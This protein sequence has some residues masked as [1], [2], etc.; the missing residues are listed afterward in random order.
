MKKRINTKILELPDLQTLII[1]I[2]NRLN[3]AIRKTQLINMV[4]ELFECNSKSQVDFAILG[5]IEQ[6]KLHYTKHFVCTSA[7]ASTW[8]GIITVADEG[9]IKFLLSIIY[10]AKADLLF[11]PYTNET[12]T[13]SNFFQYVEMK[14]PALLKRTDTSL[15]YMEHFHKVYPYLMSND[16]YVEFN[17]YPTKRW[18]TDFFNNPDCRIFIKDIYNDRYYLRLQV[19][20]IPSKNNYKKAHQQYKEFVTHIKKYFE[21]N[22]TVDLSVQLLT[23]IMNNHQRQNRKKNYKEKH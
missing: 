21:D 7:F 15:A 4:I 19:I 10:E 1:E 18:L 5:L 16:F 9:I 8:D 11:H 12:L 14:Y 17:D 2:C 20:L 3:R 6:N 22:V 13:V 23:V